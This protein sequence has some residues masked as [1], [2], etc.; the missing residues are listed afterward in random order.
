MIL[1]YK[2]R[3]ILVPV[4]LVVPI[5]GVAIISGVLKRNIGGLFAYDYD[6]QIILGIGLLISSFWTYIK[7]EDYIEV[8]G[9]KEKIEMNNHFFYI[10]MKLWSKIMVIAGVLTL[11]AGIT[12]TLE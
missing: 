10:P 7:S 3:G 12:E 1:I 11:I 9:K 5:V 4:F 2:N 6:Y 8:D